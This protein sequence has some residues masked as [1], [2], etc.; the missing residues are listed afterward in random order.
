MEKYTQRTYHNTIHLWHDDHKHEGQSGI[1]PSMVARTG[2]NR[3]MK[4]SKTFRFNVWAVDDADLAKAKGYKSCKSQMLS[5]KKD[6]IW[7]GGQQ[8]IDIA[9][10]ILI[11]L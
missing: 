10:T 1:A 5:G 3:R 6:R 2:D 8:D 4:D 11:V 7:S 9:P